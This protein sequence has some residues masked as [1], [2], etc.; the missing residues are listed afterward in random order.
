M[1]GILKSIPNDRFLKGFS[2]QIVFTFTVFSICRLTGS[3]SRIIF[4]IP[5]SWR[6]LTWGLNRGLMPIKLTHYT[7]RLRQQFSIMLARIHGKKHKVFVV[8]FDLP[9]YPTKCSQKVFIFYRLFFIYSKMYQYKVCIQFY[10][11]I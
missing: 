3:R 8:F 5:S 2:C 9:K 4:H 7:T 11:C 10:Y 6:C 1:F